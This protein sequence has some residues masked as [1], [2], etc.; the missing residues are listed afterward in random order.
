[1]DQ[2]QLIWYVCLSR[3][4]AHLFAHRHHYWL[5]CSELRVPF[6]CERDAEI[7]YNTLR[8]DPEPPRSG[9]S[10]QFRLDRGLL[11]V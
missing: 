10:K 5:L 2:E 3:Y 6:P 8:V 4:V 11:L 9:V 7:A 1:M